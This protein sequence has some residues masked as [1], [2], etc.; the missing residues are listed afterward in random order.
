MFCF[1]FGLFQE[2]LRP[3]CRGAG[4]SKLF[5]NGQ[6]G[7]SA[8]SKKVVSVCTYSMLFY[9]LMPIM[10]NVVPSSGSYRYLRKKIYKLKK[11]TRE[12]CKMRAW[13]VFAIILTLFFVLKVFETVQGIVI[14]LVSYALFLTLECSN[15]QRGTGGTLSRGPGPEVS[16][17]PNRPGPRIGLH[18]PVGVTAGLTWWLPSNIYWKSESWKTPWQ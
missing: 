15:V 12:P 8:I 1:I 18:G 5:K 11:Q 13:N 3:V 10:K 4:M 6:F 16:K 9:L 7:D 14:C 2:F 17:Q